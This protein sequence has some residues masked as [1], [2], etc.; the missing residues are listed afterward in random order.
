ARR[1]ENRGDRSVCLQPAPSA[2]GR[3][4][5]MDVTEIEKRVEKA[6]A[7]PTP[8]NAELGG[9]RL[10]NLGQVMEFAKLMSL[11]GVAV[12]KWLRG[13]PGGCLAI[14]SRALRWNMDPFAVAEQSYMAIGKG[15]IEHIGFQAQL[16]HAVITAHAPLQGR[17]GSENIGPGDDRRCHVWAPFKGE[18]KPH[19]YTS[20]T[21]G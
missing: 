7:A 10:E 19:E 2:K 9:V 17:R 15:G 5:I 8:V 12:P 20:Q 3:E 1:D 4:K 13:N 6:V 18:T 11:S 16:I 14:C 21:L